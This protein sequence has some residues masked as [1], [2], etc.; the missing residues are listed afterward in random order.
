MPVSL[1]N[2]DT[3]FPS[4]QE[5]TST[6]ERV[7][8]LTNYLYMLLEELRYTFNNL[9]SEN[10][11]DKGLEE[12]GKTITEPLYVKVEKAIDKVD[13]ASK[14][15][16]ELSVDVS[17]NAAEIKTLTDWK[18]STSSA[19]SSI[20]QKAD[21]NASSISALTQWQNSTN[22]TL[23][24]LTQTS[25]SQSASITAL[26]QWKS[27]VSTTISSIEQTVNSNS[28]NIKTLT[29]WKD[30]A[31][32][33]L[34]S[35]QQTATA[36]GA[37]ISQIVNAVGDSTGRVTEASIVAAINSGASSVKIKADKIQMTGTTTFLTSEDVGDYGATEI[38][39]NRISVKIAG[40]Y[41]DGSTNLESDNGIN[42]KYV[43][44]SG[45]ER[46]FAKI[47]TSIDG[48]DSDTTSRYALNIHA[49]KFSSQYMGYVYP[50]LKLEAAGRV[51]IT[52]QFGIYIN[53]YDYYN[54]YLTLE[55][56]DN[57]RIA[58]GK[59]HSQMTNSYYGYCFCTDGI[60]YNGTK[61]LSV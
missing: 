25:S 15:I 32:T 53:A 41:D 28:A 14:A 12:I 17:V 16:A 60:Y 1:L 58:P 5:D 26:T 6:K 11:N 45:I 3:S 39:G 2:T 29:Q 46:N 54:G 37:S 51:S 10:F 13:S 30:S 48:R 61:I 18:T 31:G 4:F 35:I 59:T 38:A 19:I 23:T 42:F 47:F 22:Q 24:S 33:T 49:A 52:G 21:A 20:Q 57:I 56:Y 55:A 8:V 9:G 36:N 40:A 44:A 27:S 7:E 50:S 43:L 34:S